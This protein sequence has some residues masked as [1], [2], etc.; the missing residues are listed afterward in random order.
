MKNWPDI[1][2]FS[3]L[4]EGDREALSTLFLRYYDQLVH[5]GV[6][7]NGQQ[8]LVEDCIQEL[9]TY[10]YEASDRL[11]QVKEV[12]IYLYKSLRRRLLAKV[13]KERKSKRIE[14]SQYRTQITFKKEDFM[15]DETDD[16]FLLQALNALPWRQ[17]E[18]V[19]LRYY[20]R[21]STKEIAGIMTVADQTVLNTLYQALKN[22]RKSGFSHDLIG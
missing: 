14:S 13:D 17:R 20:N 10:L 11:G 4:R 22:L 21:L 12:K 9:F 1:E 16:R 2:L 3:A 5:Y 8:S 19:Y 7:I 6:R 15:Q 18:A